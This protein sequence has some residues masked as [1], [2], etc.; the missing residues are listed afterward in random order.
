MKF[1]GSL[2][3]G[4]RQLVDGHGAYL[5]VAF[6]GKVTGRHLIKHW[7]TQL[8]RPRAAPHPNPFRI[9]GSRWGEAARVARSEAL[10]F[11]KVKR[12]ARFR[13]SNDIVSGQ[14]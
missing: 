13:E 11:R 3:M 4:K 9:D 10:P 8:P 5:V 6:K 7:S 1:D 2:S 12:R 14:S